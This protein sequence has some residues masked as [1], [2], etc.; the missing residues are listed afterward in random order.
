[1]K[2]MFKLGFATLLTL[3]LSHC[4]KQPSTF[5]PSIS[6]APIAHDRY[7]ESLNYY[8]KQTQEEN[9]ASVSYAKL[10]ASGRALK[11]GMTAFGFQVFSD[12]DQNTLPSTAKN[13]YQLLGASYALSDRN[14]NLAFRYLTQTELHTLEQDERLNYHQLRAKA[15]LQRNDSVAYVDELIALHPLLPTSV[16]QQNN[17]KLIMQHLVNLDMPTLQQM[18]SQS[19]ENQVSGWASLISILKSKPH[20][21]EEAKAQFMQWNE[22]FSSH[23]AQ[24][25][26]SAPALASIQTLKPKQVALL[27]PQSGPLT[28]PGS[29]ILQGFMDAQ[30]EYSMKNQFQIKVYDTDKLNMDEISNQIAKDHIDFVIGPLDKNKVNAFAKSNHQIP[31]L[32][33]NHSD[34]MLSGSIFSYGIDP[35]QEAIE[36]ANKAY[37]DG[38]RR[39]IIIRPEGMWGE[40]IK[41]AFKKAWETVGGTIIDEYAYPN[42]A[43]LSDGIQNLLKLNESH[44]RKQHIKT[45]LKREINFLPRRRQDADMIFL[46]ALPNAARQIKPMLNYYFAGQ[47]PIYATSSI[48]SGVHAPSQDK[49]LDGIIFCDMPSLILNPQRYALGQSPWPEYLNSKSRLLLLGRDAFLIMNQWHYLEH[50]PNLGLLGSSGYLYLGEQ[51]NIQRSFMWAKFDNGTAVPYRT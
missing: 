13:E 47:I 50:I 42:L 33:L 46:I 32:L 41:L 40:Q 51:R 45:I 10:Q 30:E 39:V 34:S 9:E 8:L 27:L 49:D 22:K 28:G 15:L 20:A 19:N 44:G 17:D 16:E 26:L 14:P 36:V 29:A 23:P 48:Y 37:V 24:K 25:I 7:P 31:T 43:T 35:R 38:K 12:I 6:K 21:P 1:M 2:L 18:A 11:D 4:T 3:L 5:A